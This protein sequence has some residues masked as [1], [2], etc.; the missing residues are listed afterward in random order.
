MVWLTQPL[1]HRI[2]PGSVCSF[3][4][5]R[6]AQRY[7]HDRQISARE[8][9]AMSSL[10]APFLR[11][12]EST[13]PLNASHGNTNPSERTL[14]AE[15]PDSHGFGCA[16]PRKPKEGPTWTLSFGCFTMI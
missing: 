10:T 11:N 4:K 1:A 14:K 3:M 16:S 13:I 7:G 2:V 12:C 9:F 5:F 8:C 6:V 15:M